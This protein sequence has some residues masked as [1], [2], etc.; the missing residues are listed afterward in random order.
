TKCLCDSLTHAGLWG[1]DSQI[2]DLRIVRGPVVKG[3]K[4]TVKVG[5]IAA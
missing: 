4:I 3:G 5:E 2:D 1:D